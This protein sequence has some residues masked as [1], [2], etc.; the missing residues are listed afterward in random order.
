MKQFTVQRNEN[1]TAE[2]GNLT[3]STKDLKEGTYNVSTMASDDGELFAINVIHEEVNMDEDE[4]HIGSEPFTGP[5]SI[6]PVKN[7]V[8]AE[9]FTFPENKMVLPFILTDGKDNIGLNFSANE[10]TTPQ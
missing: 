3:F 4:R 5:F 6:S 9:G 10:I 2:I 1:E 7:V 8:V